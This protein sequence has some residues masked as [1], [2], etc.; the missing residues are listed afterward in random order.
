[1]VK[2][3]Q[4]EGCVQQFLSCSR[5]LTLGAKLLCP[6]SFDMRKNVTEVILLC[7]SSSF[8]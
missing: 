8:L 3:V 7:N 5:K 1:M 4:S 2:D 6:I